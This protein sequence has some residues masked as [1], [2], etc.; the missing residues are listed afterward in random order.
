MDSA[1]YYNN[2]DE[3]KAMQHVMKNKE[4]MNSEIIHLLCELFYELRMYGIFF[5]PSRFFVL[6]DTQ[7]HKKD[8]RDNFTFMESNN[9][10]MDFLFKNNYKITILPVVNDGVHWSMLVYYNNETERNN[11]YHY[12]S[13]GLE[14]QYDLAKSLLIKYMSPMK[15]GRY[16]RA[17]IFNNNDRLNMI[18]VED[19]PIQDSNWECGYYVLMMIGLLVDRAKNGVYDAVTDKSTLEEAC[20]M[21]KLLV[22]TPKYVKFLNNYTTTLKTINDLITSEDNRVIGDRNIDTNDI[23]K[24]LNNESITYEMMHYLTKRFLKVE[25]APLTQQILISDEFKQYLIDKDGFLSVLIVGD[26]KAHL[27]DPSGTA[28]AWEIGCTLNG[29]FK[30]KM[31]DKCTTGCMI[32]ILIEYTKRIGVLLDFQAFEILMNWFTT[33]KQDIFKPNITNNVATMLYQLTISDITKNNVVSEEMVGLD[34][35]CKGNDVVALKMERNAIW[36]NIYNDYPAN[37]L[38]KY[39]KMKK[40]VSKYIVLEKYDKLMD[41][42]KQFPN[43]FMSRSNNLLH[44]TVTMNTI[45][46]N[47]KPYRQA[48]L[49][50]KDKMKMII[51]FMFYETIILFPVLIKYDIDQS[52]VMSVEHIL[53]LCK[54]ESCLQDVLNLIVTVDGYVKYANYSYNLSMITFDLQEITNKEFSGEDISEIEN[55][56][57]NRYKNRN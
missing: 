16:N 9:Y 30:G 6:D 14:S 46:A 17:R 34:Y 4:F 25:L 33:R 7:A 36:Q 29:H 3:V 26:N 15:L 19:Y 54:F 49:N 18:E 22:Q 56:L 43:K 35:L 10:T 1:F 21:N 5:L 32:Y 48:L 37:L 44:D 23:S 53:Y 47:L 45:T 40:D 8:R 2:I 51:D 38:V 31:L 42:L 24:L 12:D 28:N 41:Y 13:L 55:L 39:N 20:N 11:V 52:I 50:S 27:Y 57:R